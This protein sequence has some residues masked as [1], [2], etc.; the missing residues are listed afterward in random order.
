MLLLGE[1]NARLLIISLVQANF[2]LKLPDLLLDLLLALASLFYLCFVALLLKR[3]QAHLSD[4][5]WVIDVCEVEGA[6][7]DGVSAFARLLLFGKLSI[8]FLFFR[9]CR[10]E[11]VTHDGVHCGAARRVNALELLVH[12]EL[13]Q[14]LQ[15][16]AQVDMALLFG[17]LNDLDGGDAHGGEGWARAC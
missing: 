16:T 8:D 12:V 1:D 3:V 17:L 5:E 9:R 2:L 7:D 14:I 15:R 6:G 4:L 13:A 10:F 11:V